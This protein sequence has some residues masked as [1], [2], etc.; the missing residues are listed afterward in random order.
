[1][2]RLTAA[3]VRAIS[4]PGWHG[5]G[6]TLYLAVAPRGSKSWVQR[7]TINGARRDLGLGG[8]PLVSLA[9]ARRLAFENRKVARE[10][11]NPTA[12]RRKLPTFR[13]AARNVYES[14]KDGWQSAKVKKNWWQ[15]M[16]RHA[17]P[18]LG[19]MRVDQ[20]GPPHVLRVLG[21]IWKAAP[22]TARRIRRHIRATLAWCEMHEFVDK[23]VAG[24]ALDAGL[25]PRRRVTAHFRALPHREVAGALRTIEESGASIAAKLCL[26][27]LVLTAARSGE[28]R[29]ARCEEVESRTWTVPAG[30]MKQQKEH[31]VPLSDAALAVLAE[32][33]IL[34]DGSGLVF[35]S[36]VKRGKPLSDMTLMKLLRDTGLAHRATVHG[37]RSSFRDWCAESEAPG[38]IAEAALAHAVGGVKGAY[39]RSDFFERRRPLMDEWARY[40]SNISEKGAL[41]RG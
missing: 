32:A 14:R 29:G 34:E 31:R 7:L 30:R 37:F 8:Y 5:D 21:P 19:D 9:E 4:E 28:A 17:L 11:G 24:P 41:S 39:L 1:M 25:D 3:Q 12:A 2:G 27:F 16:E 6:D 35:P 40:L 23:N 22:E 26:R 15:Q 13:E 18:V 10:G 20:I 36:P 38:E 33:R